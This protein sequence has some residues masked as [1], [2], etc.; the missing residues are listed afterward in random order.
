M[1]YHGPDR[2]RRENCGL[3]DAVQAQRRI[4]KVLVNCEP[5][6]RAPVHQEGRLIHSYSRVL[7][8]PPLYCLY[9]VHARTT[10]LAPPDSIP[11]S[12]YTCSR[13]SILQNSQALDCPFWRSLY[14]GHCIRV[15]GIFK[16]IA[17]ATIVALEDAPNSCQSVLGS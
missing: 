9:N 10:G 13:S 1:G 6:A 16:T 14:L 5:Q 7:Q 11:L 4:T 8:R 3:L 17:S 15:P 12:S 2:L